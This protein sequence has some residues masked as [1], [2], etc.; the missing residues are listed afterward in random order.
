MP[1]AMPPKLDR[2]GSLG[3]RSVFAGLH[4]INVDSVLVPVLSLWSLGK[5][6]REHC[7]QPLFSLGLQNLGSHPRKGE[8]QTGAECLPLIVSKAAASCPL[9]YNPPAACR[10]TL[11]TLKLTVPF[12]CRTSWAGNGL[13][14]SQYMASI[15]YKV[16]SDSAF[17]LVQSLWPLHKTP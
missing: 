17:L 8:V 13:W 4:N 14:E 6:L 15:F 7:Y 9:L 5:M 12:R 16:N 3:F 11:T 10:E 1:S 2:L